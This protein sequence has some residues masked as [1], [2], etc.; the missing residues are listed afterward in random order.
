MSADQNVKAGV[1]ARYAMMKKAIGEHISA[2]SDKDRRA[3]ARRFKQRTDTI[4]HWADVLTDGGDQALMQSAIRS[5]NA[6]QWAKDRRS[7]GTRPSGRAKKK[8]STVATV[9][10]ANS[11]ATFNVSVKHEQLSPIVSAVNSRVAYCISGLISEV[12]ASG[13][14][15]SAEAAMLALIDQSRLGNVALM[16]NYVVSKTKA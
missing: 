1:M 3:V 13:A 7:P 12:V 11:V 8:E 15:G 5:Y 16:G 10:Q 6:V 2:K 4:E 9:V 14:Y